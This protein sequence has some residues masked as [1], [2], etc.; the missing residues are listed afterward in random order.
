ML[1]VKLASSGCWR[2]GSTQLLRMDWVH[3]TCEWRHWTSWG[4]MPVASHDVSVSRDVMI[5]SDIIM[6][7][8]VL[9]WRDTLSS[10]GAIWRH[11]AV[12]PWCHLTSCH[13]PLWHLSLTVAFDGLWWW[14]S[15][16]V[17]SLISPHKTHFASNVFRAFY[18]K[19]FITW[20]TSIQYKLA[21]CCTWAFGY[22][23]FQATS[24]LMWSP[25]GGTCFGAFIIIT[26]SR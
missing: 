6:P 9:L 18:I 2:P 22:E 10:C 23:R 15:M 12:T 7:R 20:N 1:T 3:A 21:S 25:F 24:L 8:N 16:A 17:F 19:L 26:L 5:S 4:H 11:V 14:F 13:S